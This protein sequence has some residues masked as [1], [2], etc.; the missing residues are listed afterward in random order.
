[1]AKSWNNT[2]F[3]EADAAKPSTVVDIHSHLPAVDYQK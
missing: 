1:M 2:I 3:E